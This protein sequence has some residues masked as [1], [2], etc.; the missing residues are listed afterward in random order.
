MNRA[1]QTHDRLP[2]RLGLL[3]ALIP[4]TDVDGNARRRNEMSLGAG[5]CSNF[6][7][8]PAIRTEELP[9]NYKAY[10]SLALSISISPFVN[11]TAGQGLASTP[12]PGLTNGMVAYW[13]LDEVQGTKTP[14]VVRGYDM[15]LIN[16][17]A[18]D[19]VTGKWGKAFKFTSARST[20][21]ER[22]NAL[23]DLIPLYTKHT[24]FSLSLWVNGP[25]NQTD[26]R[27]FCESSTTSN[28]PLFDFGTHQTGADGSVDSYIRTDTGATAGDHQWTFNTAYDDTWHHLVYVQQ[29]VAGVMEG[30]FYI[31]GVKDEGRDQPG[32]VRPI[33]A[34]ITAIGG[35][36]RGS[37]GAPT[38][39]F[40]FDGMIDDV[41]MWNRALSQAEITS[42]F[43][44]GTP[45]PATSVAQPLAIRSFKA[46][47]PAVAKGDSI[48]LRWDVSKDVTQVDIDQGIGA[49]TT[50][51]VVGIGSITV[52]IAST[53]TFTLTVRRG[54]ET[55][56][57]SATVVA[58][59]GVTAN[60]ALLDDFE[61]YNVGAFPSRWW[62]DLG[63]N[64][65][66]VS[67]NTNKMLD[68]RGTARIA[69]L[70]LNDLTV[71]QGQQRTL[72]TRIY[73]QGDI[74]AAIRSRFG[75][76]DRGLRFVTDITDQ[77]GAGP[78]AFISNQ[79]GELMIGSRFGPG[80]AMDFMP[81]TLEVDSVY[82][83]WIDVKNDPID[84]GDT[85]SIWIQ[86]EGE[87]T[88]TK[89]IADYISDRDPAGDP[90]AN[91]GVPTGPD[92]TKI[93]LG[94]DG[95]NAV[96]FDDVYISKSGYNSTIPHAL[97][98]TPTPGGQTN[99]ALIA[100][101]GFE[102]PV[103][104]I[105]GQAGGSGWIAAWQ[106]NA[107][108]AG[109]SLVQSGSLSYTDAKGNSLVTSGGKGFVTGLTGT[110]QPYREIPTLLGT[111]GTKAWFSYIGMRTGPTTNNAVEPDNIYPRGANVSMFSSGTEHLGV[112]NPTGAPT[113]TWTLLPAGVLAN[114]QPTT[115][116]FDKVSFVVV[117]IDFQD[118]NDD[119]YLWV[120]PPL[121]VE[122]NITTASAQ[123]VGSFD[124][125]FN[126]IRPF[127]GNV[128]AANSRP[129][130]ELLFDEIRVGRTFAAVAPF[131]T[132]GGT[133]PKV[134]ITRSG[135]QL[136]ISWTTGT[137]ESANSITGPW[138]AVA[139]AAAP[140][141]SVAPS[142]SQRYFRIRQ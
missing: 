3:S 117:R 75:L 16:L 20:M 10:L 9:M 11:Q 67:V 38:R 72:F 126:R 45:K 124:F 5:P 107:S 33:T 59:D 120:N 103:G 1:T 113:N 118:G 48:T 15:S 51:T 131:T 62:G 37:A 24:N 112:G 82:N 42:L 61:Q 80:G 74:T 136:Q 119:A 108:P 71:K 43:T 7:P 26:K 36:R 128:Q 6:G 140:S 19:L 4:V 89:V 81:P 40:F 41:A 96:F 64:S 47:L 104:D 50:N 110:A 100:Y 139:G 142:G 35:V 68:M 14:E 101:D 94:N 21:M 111:T 138:T 129:Q 135:T 92:L 12:A 127:A 87:T 91:G 88:R 53:K 125:S 141:Y 122:P 22:E 23:T 52:P 76:T 32:P 116:R 123:S 106:A 29:V 63:G 70:S 55:L 99:S 78:D 46:D 83:V 39:Q 114:V 133:A 57:N 69:I 58:V 13:P 54:T 18:A 137:L 121:D 56:T 73:V 49:V 109:S 17:T 86:K 28:N 105:P 65:Q 79:N 130:A 90:A 84:T 30:V 95:A 44:Q 27:I 98:S 31:D 60:W 93:F 77:G 85:F 25:A 102:Y 132:G 134:S 8:A 34:N 66:I 115:A 97:G 2:E